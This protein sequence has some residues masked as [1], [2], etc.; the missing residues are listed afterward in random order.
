MV[1]GGEGGGSEVV[2]TN[3]WCGYDYLLPTFSTYGTI[4][5]YVKCHETLEIRKWL[6][7]KMKNPEMLSFRVRPVNLKFIYII[8]GIVWKISLIVYTVTTVSQS[9]YYAFCHECHGW[10]GQTVKHLLSW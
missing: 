4:N 6:E 8:S 7:L 10:T 9:Q 3:H 1:G 2:K 5:M